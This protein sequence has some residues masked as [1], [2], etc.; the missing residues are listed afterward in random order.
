MITGSLSDI[1]HPGASVQSATLKRDDRVP[2]DSS[3]EGLGHVGV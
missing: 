3:V 2:M 1:L